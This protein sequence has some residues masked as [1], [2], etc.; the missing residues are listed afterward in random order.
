M[1][2]TD[3]SPIIEIRNGYVSIKGK[4]RPK[5][6]YKQ[7]KEEMKV[8]NK[9]QG[10]RSPKSRCYCKKLLEVEKDDCVECKEIISEMEMLKYLVDNLEGN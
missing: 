4:D 2:D 3:E 10:N 6:K 8:D 7:V 1:D 5:N 9:N